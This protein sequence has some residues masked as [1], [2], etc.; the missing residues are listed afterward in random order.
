MA[1]DMFLMIDGVR[2]DSQDSKYSGC[3]EVESFEHGV[4]QPSGG[5]AS[6]QG[7]L[8]GGRVD[9]S[10]FVFHK[11]VDSAT[12]TI[13]MFCCQGKH[14][15]HITFYLCRAMGEKTLFMEYRFYDSIICSTEVEGVKSGDDPIPGEAVSL[16]YGRIEWEYTP[17]DPTGGGK[18]GPSVH[19]GWSVLQNIPT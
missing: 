13:A 14:I 8:A 5:A 1:Y 2:G 4:S 11:R 17:T 7:A 6:A 12:P 15:P 10:D 18:V 3:I 19:G 9:H 16:R